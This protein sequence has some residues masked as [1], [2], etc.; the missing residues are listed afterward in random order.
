MSSP[1]TKTDLEFLKRFSMLIGVLA[2]M[3]LAFILL[4]LYIY[5]K[6]PAAK[7]PDAGKAVTE[8]IAPVGDSYAGDTGRAAMLAAEEARKKAAAAQVAYG[9]TT[10]GKVIYDQ[11]CGACHKAGISGAPKLDDKADWAPRLAQG[12]DTLIKH[13][14][15]G[16][17]GKKGVMP[18]RGGNPSLNDEQIKATVHWMIE[19]TK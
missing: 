11:L 1:I 14:T 7:S 2:L 9:G 3:A 4:A 16:F 6:H 8:R 19:Q 18:A 13:A 12:V 10:D 15:E 5:A 17:T